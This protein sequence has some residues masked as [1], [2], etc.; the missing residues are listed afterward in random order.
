MVISLI[1]VNNTQLLEHFKTARSISILCLHLCQ[2]IIEHKKSKLCSHSSPRRNLELQLSSLYCYF[3][4]VVGLTEVN[5]IPTI[6]GVEIL[7]VTVM[8]RSREHTGVRIVYT[9]FDLSPEGYCDVS[10]DIEDIFMSLIIR[11]SVTAM[12][13]FLP[14]TPEYLLYHDRGVKRL[15]DIL[16]EEVFT[17]DPNVESLLRLRM[18]QPKHTDD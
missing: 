7:S 14:Q 10:P 5:Y 3:N 9:M 13:A 8:V 1:K 15:K 18:D 6:P 4:K 11:E 12:R 2:Y 16:G 17:P